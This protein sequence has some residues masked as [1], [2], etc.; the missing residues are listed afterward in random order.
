[1]TQ[2][3]YWWNTHDNVVMTAAWM[4]D[5]GHSAKDLALLVEKPWKWTDEFALAEAEYQKEQSS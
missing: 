4:A 2:P 5:N 3:D 1:M